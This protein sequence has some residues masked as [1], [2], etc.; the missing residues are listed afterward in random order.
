VS[1]ICY[2][3]LKTDRFE[4]QFGVRALRSGET[5][6]ERTES[7]A[8]EVALKCQLID[9]D[10]ANYVQLTSAS[11]ASGREAAELL[12]G[13]AQSLVDVAVAIQEDLVILSGDFATG[14]P[15]TAGVVCFPS[16]WSIADKIGQPIDSVHHSVPEYAELMSRGTRELLERLKPN[17]PVWRTNWGVRSSGLLD[18]SPKRAQVLN[19][20]TESLTSDNVGLRCHFRV[21]RQT[22]SRLPVS[23][24]I[25]FTI[26]THQCPIGDLETWQQRNLLGVLKTSP[27]ATLQYKGIAPL[28]SLLCADLQCRLS[29]DETDREG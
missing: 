5:I 24:D 1:A 21:E 14:Y 4:H 23:G 19:E 25:L 15:I 18:Q 10:R 3:P 13:R 26:H 2:F 29:A 22:L 8:A 20:R 11:E 16:G 17:R 28:A 12:T 9:E 6:V 7:F 27:I